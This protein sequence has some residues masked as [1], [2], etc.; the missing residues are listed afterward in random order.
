MHDLVSSD[1]QGAYFICRGQ[2]SRILAFKFFLRP[3]VFCFPCSTVSRGNTTVES[4]ESEEL[5]A[6]INIIY[7]TEFDYGADSDEKCMR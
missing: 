7:F 4:R 5:K 2:S 1:D 6:R 3:G